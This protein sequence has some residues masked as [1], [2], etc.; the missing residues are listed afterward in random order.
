MRRDSTPPIRWPRSGT[1]SCGDDESLIYLDGNS[2]GPLPLATAARIDAVVR[3]EWGG[4]LVRSW[5]DWIE[6]PPRAGDLLGGT[7]SARRPARWRSA[8]PP[9]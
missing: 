3:Q 2:L 9:R 6:L 1:G 4:R 7:C 5:P 8:I